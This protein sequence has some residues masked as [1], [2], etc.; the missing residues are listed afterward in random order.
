M[1]TSCVW[2]PTNA[3]LLM[4]REEFIR[5]C[6]GDHCA[7]SLLAIFE[8]WH[9]V[10]LRQ[11]EQE[12]VRHAYDPNYSPNVEIWVYKSVEDL[13]VDLLGLYG[14]R[15]VRDSLAFLVSRQYVQTRPNPKNTYDRTKQYQLL[16][17]RVSAALQ[18]L[19]PSDEA[20]T[21]PI[22]RDGDGGTDPAKMQHRSCKN[23]GSSIEAAK[24]QDRSGK[25]ATLHP[26]KLPPPKENTETTLRD[27]EVVVSNHQKPTV[28]RS[29]PG[30]KGKPSKPDDDRTPPGKIEYA[31]PRDELVALIR[32]RTGELPERQLVRDIDELVELR[33]GTLP[34]YLAD[35]RPRLKRL[36]RPPTVA[37]F[38]A[39][40]RKWG[41]AGQRAAPEPRT[42]AAALEDTRTCRECNWGHRSDG[43]FCNCD[44][45]VDLER[46]AKRMAAAK[47]AGKTGKVA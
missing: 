42:K 6:D 41:T 8:Y 44:L 2:H 10:R 3:R 22:E 46:V 25:K 39:Q 1:R 33:G 14:E 35:I 45:G 31:T 30:V 18:D 16:P 26:A 40:A 5:L 24:M 38:F 23:A 7:A 9:N 36:S 34:A 32:E 28:H 17:E 27:S 43:S 15:K 11:I 4:V 37:F 19:F 29:A 13:A 47:H 12:H 21:A 20:V